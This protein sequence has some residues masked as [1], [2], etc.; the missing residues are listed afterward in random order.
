MRK[1]AL[2]LVLLTTASASFA[3]D[4]AKRPPSFAYREGKAVFGDF[5]RAHYDVRY[6]VAAR[7]AI[8]QSTITLVTAENGYPIFDSHEAPTVIA[9]NGQATRAPLIETPNK[10]TTLRVVD[11]LL[12]A[13][14]HTLTITTP[15]TLSLEFQERGVHSA[16]W[17]SD[18][19]E[20]GYLE[21]YLPTN[22][23]FDRIPVTMRV[24]YLNSPSRPVIY[25]NA[26]V[27][28][29]K[30][31]EFLLSFP[32]GY[33]SSCHYFHTVPE[34]SFSELRFSYKTRDGRDLPVI[35]YTP[36][37]E[38]RNLPRWRQI[39]ETHMAVLEGDYGDFPHD[40]LVIYM[41]GA[42]SGGMEYAGAT[43]T[44]ESA[45]KHEL[46]HNYF[47]RGVLPS[48]G[49]SGWIDEAL[50]RWHDNGYQS[51]TRLDGGSALAAHPVYTRT[52]DRLAY[53]FGERFIALLDGQLKSQGGLMPFLRETVAKRSFDPLS[54][55]DFMA[56]MGRFYNRSFEAEF[57]RYVFGRGNFKYNLRVEPEFDSHH[58]QYTL[59]E[60]KGML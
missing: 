29:V 27:R 48:D 40:K 4:L 1:L 41:N 9:V 44:S 28:E 49:N 2:G 16:F 26:E 11:T 54:T 30:P 22:F 3:G 52:T 51:I 47:A 38:A 7:T 17:M 18:L 46:F 45:L 37:E 6:D 20:R 23:L 21:R 15:I 19:T 32:A 14:V 12:P 60:L 35:M 43:I 34:G 10:E 53:S 39:T 56:D 50:A 31:N 25:T 59:E 42:R 55:Q 13:G 33:N 58:K 57:G 24:T 5:I 36:H 8:A